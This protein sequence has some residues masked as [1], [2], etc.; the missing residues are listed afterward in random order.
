M[1]ND[2]SGLLSDLPDAYGYQKGRDQDE[3]DQRG[4]M[5]SAWN[6]TPDGGSATFSNNGDGTV[7]KVRSSRDVPKTTGGKASTTRPVVRPKINW[8]SRLIGNAIKGGGRWSWLSLIFLRSD[9][10]PSR[11]YPVK[12]MRRFTVNYDDLS[13]EELREVF[14]RVRDGDADDYDQNIYYWA[15]LG[16]R[17]GGNTVQRHHYVT[18]K[19]TGADKKKASIVAQMHQIAKYYCLNL[20][21]DWNTEYYSNL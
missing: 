10:G 17:K 13:P 5:R 19:G 3:M 20:D 6:G 21:G 16:A 15:V 11:A 8:V 9:R 14:D 12:P 4:M 1:F 18:N 2:P 7:S